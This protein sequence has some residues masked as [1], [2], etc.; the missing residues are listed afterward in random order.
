[1]NE[2]E[3]VKQKLKNSIL[4]RNLSNIW[5]IEYPPRLELH[6]EWFLCEELNTLTENMTGDKSFK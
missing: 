1:M 5:P 3:K 4:M 6:Y 2:A